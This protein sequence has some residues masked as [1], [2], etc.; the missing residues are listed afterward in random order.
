M[1]LSQPTFQKHVPSLQNCVRKNIPGVFAMVFKSTA[2]TL[3]Q[4]V[5]EIRLKVILQTMD[6][7]L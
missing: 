4:F 2:I 1:N 7:V 6:I 5:Q 3:R